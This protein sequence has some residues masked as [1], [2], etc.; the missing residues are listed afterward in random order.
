[1]IEAKMF[2]QLD[3]FS[4]EMTAV[5]LGAKTRKISDI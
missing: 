5:P 2:I 3:P 4:V 1:M